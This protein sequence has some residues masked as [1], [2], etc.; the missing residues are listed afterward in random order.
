[1]VS[2]FLYI[3]VYLELAVLFCT[4]PIST[5]WAQYSGTGGTR[6][7]SQWTRN[8]SFFRRYW[9]LIGR[10]RRGY[11]EVIGMLSGGYFDLIG[12]LSEAYGELMGRSF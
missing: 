3:V 4:C 11:G 9:E 6:V 5:K 2:T 7:D 1:M 8:F 12:T 10:L